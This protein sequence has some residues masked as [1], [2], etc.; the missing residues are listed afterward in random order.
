MATALASEGSSRELDELR[1]KRVAEAKQALA[2]A[3]ERW[4]PEEARAKLVEPRRAPPPAKRSAVAWQAI[5]PDGYAERLAI[6]AVSREDAEQALRAPRQPLPLVS[7]GTIMRSALDEQRSTDPSAAP[8]WPAWQAILAE[9]DGRCLPSDSDNREKCNPPTI[10]NGFLGPSRGGEWWAG[11]RARLHRFDVV[12]EHLGNVDRDMG[13]ARGLACRAALALALGE[14]EQPTEGAPIGNGGEDFRADA[15]GRLV[16]AIDVGTWAGRAGKG[17][18]PWWKGRREAMRLA[19]GLVRITPIRQSRCRRFAL[20]GAVGLR[21]HVERLKDGSIAS[22]LSWNGAETCGSVWACPECSRLIRTKRAQDLGRLQEWA[23]TGAY[24]VSLTVRHAMGLDLRWLRRGVANA[25]RRVVRGQPWQ[26][27]LARAGLL[28]YVRALETTHG[29][30]GWHPHLHLIVIGTPGWPSTMLG[31]R[32][33]SEWLGARWANA[34]EAE[35]GPEQRPD[36]EHGCKVTQLAGSGYLIKMG[37]ELV[38]DWTKQARPDV[39]NPRRGPWQIAADWVRFHEPEDRALWQ[40][41]AEGMKGAQQLTWSRGLRKLA[42]L[43]QELPDEVIATDGGGREVG[44]VSRQDWEWLAS[45]VGEQGYPWTAHALEVG[46]AKGLDA[47]RD[48]IERKRGK[49]GAPSSVLRIG[50]PRHERANHDRP[51]R[52]STSDR[53]MGRGDEQ[54]RS[55]RTGNRGEA[56]SAQGEGSQAFQGSA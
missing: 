8:H 13:R 31:N 15:D 32:T 5:D 30:N 49:L 47:M 37:L 40:A 6:E 12:G 24:L 18:P 36:H 45:G 29:P 27:F 10:S 50:Q 43:E 1:R 35:L 33:A 28:G 55:N 4:G 7:M 56:R 16:G 39:R 42:S 34:V 48:W 53:T 17:A 46:E 9:T 41:Y 23:G 11:A 52:R 44:S 26:R 25:W 51:D 3:A 14:T 20:G 19:R 54:S 38:I 2:E 22:R 21:Q